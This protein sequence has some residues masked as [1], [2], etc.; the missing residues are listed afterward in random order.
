MMKSAVNT[1][2][3]SRVAGPHLA[4]VC[5]PPPA[6]VVAPIRFRPDSEANKGKRSLTGPCVISIQGKKGATTKF[7]SPPDY[8]TSASLQAFMAGAADHFADISLPLGGKM[9]KLDNE[10][11]LMIV[12]KIQIFD[13]W[14]QPSSRVKVS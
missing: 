14:L 10:H 9:T 3:A 13:L 7:V 4:P 11:L 1:S 8:S 2:R 5:T 12:P 6:S